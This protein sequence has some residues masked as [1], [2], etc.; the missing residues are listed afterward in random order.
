MT[1]DV[2][3]ENTRD[4]ATGEEEG[5]RLDPEPEPRGRAPEPGH[6]HT[7]VLGAGMAGLA[8]ADRLADQGERVT[9]LEA[10]DRTGGRI[11]SVHTWDGATLDAG[12]SWMRGEEN[13]PLSHLVREAGAR[14]AIFN[15]S[16]ETAYDPKGR[17]L[18][19]DRHRRNMEDVN[20][21]HEHMYWA[22]VSAGREE[23]MDQGLHHAL[24]D[25]NLVRARARDAVEIVHRI[26]EA[27]HGADTGEIA[28]TAVGAGHEFS[29]DDVVFP[30]GMGQLTDHLARG[31]DVRFEHV[32][33]SVEHHDDGVRVRVETPAGEETLTADRVLVTL[34][35]GVLRSGQVAFD[36]PL[37]EAKQG[38][39][40]RLGNGRLEKLF[41]RFDEVFWGDAEVIVHLGTEEGT[42][43][44][45]YSGQNVFGV[46]VLVCRNGGNAARFLADK[47]D[48]EV[49][50]HAMESLRGMFKKA[51]DPIDHYLTH[52]M[53][54]PFARGGFSFN[55]VGSGDEDRVALADPIGERVFFAGEATDVEHSATVHG[56]MLSGLR[57]AA[58][59]LALD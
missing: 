21:L 27:D 31:L 25:V 29:G 17:R 23:S 11:H 5:A 51:P 55:A 26:A 41:L 6:G 59:I 2:N 24:Y 12:A 15:R 42:W 43:F 19:F 58:R 44:H 28:F 10:R 1:E 35:L 56:A 49:V 47:E 52:W 38:S 8:A 37:P 22:T 34:P 50:E 39:L 32:V 30:E 7:I 16:T 33:L 14:T 3:G 36:P 40:E 46:P 45:W 20:L 9:V 48:G 13:N 53:D 57:E 4:E 54:D 18:L